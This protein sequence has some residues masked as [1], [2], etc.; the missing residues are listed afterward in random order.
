MKDFDFPARGFSIV[1]RKPARAWQGEPKNSLQ[2]SEEC[3][4]FG[5]YEDHTDMEV[6]CGTESICVLDQQGECFMVMFRSARV[7][8][9]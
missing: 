1:W 3:L 2:A 4:V 9:P 6:C 7:K 8:L 5:S